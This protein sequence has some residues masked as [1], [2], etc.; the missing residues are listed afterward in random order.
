MSVSQKTIKT[1]WDSFFGTPSSSNDSP[2]V[3]EPPESRNEIECPSLSL[4]C[5][6]CKSIFQ[7]SQR[8]KELTLGQA[9]TYSL[10]QNLLELDISARSGCH[11][12]YLRSQ[13]LSPIERA[14][15]DVTAD[16]KFGFW[17]SSVGDGIASDFT[18]LNTE[19]GSSPYFS[20]STLIRPVKGN[21]LAFTWFSF[22]L[23]TG[24]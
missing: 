4:L 2:P 7:G 3:P 8:V 17:K 16:I 22:F 19:Q 23:T 24:Y 14:Q 5:K 15:V 10:G 1:L 9:A 11:L 13:Q 18:I 20:K 21:T 6:V 12:C